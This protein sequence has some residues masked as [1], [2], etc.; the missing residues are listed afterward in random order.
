MNPKTGKF[1]ISLD[2]ELYWGMFDR[3]SIEDYGDNIKGERVAI[4]MTLDVFK[5]YNLHATWACVGMATFKTLDDLKAAAPTRTPSYKDLNLSSYG[6]INSGMVRHDE[7]IDPY[8]FG[9]DLVRQ[10]R[11][12]PHQEIGSHTF[13]HY[14]CLEPGQTAQE[15]E[16]DLDAQAQLFPARSIV[17]PRNQV[18][19][20]Y[21]PLCKARGL[22][23]YRGNEPH[24][25]YAPRP[26]GE[27]TLF[28]RGLRLLDH[29]LPIT[30]H[31]TYPLSDVAKGEMANV[32]A[33]RFLRP[34]NK[35]LAIFDPV[36]I[37]RIK[38][39]MEYAATHNE[40]FHLWWHPHNF[41]GTVDKNI[42]LFIE[43]AEQYAWLS[44]TYGMESATMSEIADLA[45]IRHG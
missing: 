8:H 36:R 26:E 45:Q 29:Y 5:K 34:Y 9:A 24:Y 42:P 27:E 18:N 20:A 44:R 1:V 17:F 38:T 15:F 10:I 11:E 25:L 31:N 33:S 21:L 14:Y 22:T 40:I 7:L 41:G 23:N 19:P 12:V 2:F 43:L 35:R 30:G 37:A 28:I 32:P 4:P 3:V 6:H 16:A 13:S 39:S